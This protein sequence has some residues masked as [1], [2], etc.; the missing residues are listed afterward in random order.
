M[1]NLNFIIII[2]IAQILFFELRDLNFDLSNTESF[3]LVK[4]NGSKDSNFLTWTQ[5]CSLHFTKNKSSKALEAAKLI[6]IMSDH[7]NSKSVTK[8]LIQHIASLGF[9]RSA[10]ILRGDRVQRLH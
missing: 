7:C 6:K 3:N 2:I 8:V 1:V 9:L 5:W 10:Y 4:R